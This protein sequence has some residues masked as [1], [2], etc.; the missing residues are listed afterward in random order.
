MIQFPEYFIPTKYNGY[1]WNTND[2][3]LYS[4]KSG[5]LKPIKL[6]KKWKQ[7]PECYQVSIKGERR[8]MHLNYLRGLST[9]L[10]PYIIPQEK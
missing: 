9:P 6:G 3:H 5:V 4:I 1:F 10:L 2:M 8:T 7:H